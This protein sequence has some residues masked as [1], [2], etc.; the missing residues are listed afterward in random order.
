MPSSTRE[1]AEAFLRHLRSN[2]EWFEYDLGDQADLE[3]ILVELH[4][5]RLSVVEATRRLTDTDRSYVEVS[6]AGTEPLSSVVKEIGDDTE[7]GTV[8]DPYEARPGID[9][10]EEETSARILTSEFPV[11]GYT[12][13]LSISDRVQRERGDF[14]LQPH[15]T[16]IVWG[17][18]KVFFVFQQGYARVRPVQRGLTDVGAPQELR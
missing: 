14:F 6:S 7:E 5:G 18:R 1:G 15:S 16:R 12:C 8:P 4:A 9:R 10:R 11:N 13:F 2:R 3:E 17:G